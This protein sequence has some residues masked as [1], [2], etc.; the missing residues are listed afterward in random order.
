MLGASTLRPP[1]YGRSMQGL[2]GRAPEVPDD[3]DP[4]DDRRGQRAH[5]LERG[6]HQRA[7]LAQ[8]HRQ[9]DRQV[10]VRLVA[11]AAGARLAAP[12]RCARAGKHCGGAARALRTDDIGPARAQLLLLVQREREVGYALGQ[13]VA[14]E[15][16][17]PAGRVH[18]DE[19]R[20]GL[21]PRRRAGR[22]LQPCLQLGSLRPCSGRRP[23]RARRDRTSST[24]Q[25]T[26]AQCGR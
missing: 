2:G 3:G 1:R 23:R 25:R 11:C 20:G 12:L 15:R 17:R 8:H 26:A 7:E 10:A 16:L 5:G 9:R 21:A 14:R 18:G 24:S 22:C 19:E 6:R 13:R 4:E